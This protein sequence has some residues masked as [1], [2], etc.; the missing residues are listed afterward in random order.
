MD[1]EI[2]IEYIQ[3]LYDIIID[4]VSKTVNK[5]E[6]QPFGSYNLND[7]IVDDI[8]NAKT[9]TMYHGHEP[10]FFV[11]RSAEIDKISLDITKSNNIDEYF[12]DI[13]VLLYSQI[14]E[15][16][17]GFASIINYGT[18]KLKSSIKNRIKEEEIVNDHWLFI[19]DEVKM[20][21]NASYGMCYPYIY[22]IL[23]FKMIDEAAVRP[24]GKE[25]L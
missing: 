9:R 12:L 13:E 2:D 19:I 18:D 22:F 1:Q 25:Y 11:E 15:D 8:R 16:R 6:Y 21:A 10:K 20:G 14:E 3:V 17:D 7:L 4:E 23:K 24:G 5:G